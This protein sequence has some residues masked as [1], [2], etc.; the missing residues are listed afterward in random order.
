MNDQTTIEL[1][2]EIQAHGETI[3]ALVQK[4]QGRTAKQYNAAKG[5]ED[6]QAVAIEAMGWEEEG[7]RMLRLGFMSLTRAV[8]QPSTFA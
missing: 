3:K 1:L 5:D 6:L 2:N 8:A 4:V 7:T